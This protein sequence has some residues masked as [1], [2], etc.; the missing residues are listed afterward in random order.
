MS[1]E[2]FF[3]ISIL[4]KIV[5]VINHNKFKSKRFRY[6]TITTVVEKLKIDLIVQFGDFRQFI[7]VTM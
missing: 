2:R 5:L 1:F 6:I 4:N 3:F 7:E